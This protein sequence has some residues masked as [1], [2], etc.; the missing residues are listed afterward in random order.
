MDL[1]IYL[2]LEIAL[3]AILF[4][5]RFNSTGGSLPIVIL[6]HT[7]INTTY[8]FLPVS[9]LASIL[10]PLLALVMMIWM[11]RSPQTF[12]PRQE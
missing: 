12:S 1:L 11:W 4:T 9:S 6:L 3:F 7:F 2:L 8:L 10:W 5:T